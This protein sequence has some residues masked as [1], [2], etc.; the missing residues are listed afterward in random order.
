MHCGLWQSV[1][2]GATVLTLASAMVA[3]VAA[4]QTVQPRA[5]KMRVAPAY[6]NLGLRYHLAGVVKLAVIV[7]ANG[8][9]KSS[10]VV[11]GNPLLA[12]AAQEAVKK[13][14]FE[15]AKEETT[16]IISVAFQP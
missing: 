16:E 6:P 4:A 15:P 11:G 7:A 1:R 14:E 10:R 8:R 12:Q 13:W 2:E 9:V 5:V 3:P